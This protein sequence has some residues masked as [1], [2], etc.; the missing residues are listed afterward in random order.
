MTP[1]GPSRPRARPP[2]CS[3]AATSRARWFVKSSEVRVSDHLKLS[4]HQIRQ[5]STCTDKHTD[6]RAVERKKIQ[7]AHPKNL[8]PIA[9]DPNRRAPSHAQTPIDHTMMAASAP[10]S[11]RLS[12][13]TGA[14]F[15]RAAGKQARLPAVRAQRALAVSAAAKSYKI[16][17]LPGDGIGPEI[18]KTAREVLELSL[19]HI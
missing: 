13:S 19:I 14:S 2:R 15:R 4:S 5:T 12:A 6:D 3:V 11:F 8:H 7:K 16:T 1:A 10:V 9:S 18:M 17:L